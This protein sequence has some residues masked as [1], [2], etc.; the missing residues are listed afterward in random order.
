MDKKEYTVHTDEEIEQL[1][2]N[3]IIKDVSRFLEY[4][5]ENG[6]VKELFDE[7]CKTIDY[8]E[9][10]DTGLFAH[11]TMAYGYKIG[12]EILCRVYNSTREE[13]SKELHGYIENGF[14]GF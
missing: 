11:L 13:M 6:T 4:D 12:V 7:L 2:D 1:K 5:L 10:Y 3:Q 8:K 14:L 9:M